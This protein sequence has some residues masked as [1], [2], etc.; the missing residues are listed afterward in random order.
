MALFGFGGDSFVEVVSGI[1][2][3][4]M[5]RRIRISGTENPDPFQQ[6]A[7]TITGTGFYVLVL[8]LSLTA[9]VGLYRGH[10]PDTTFWGFVVSVVSLVT[11][12]LLIHYKVEVGKQLNSDAILSDAAGTRACFSFQS[13]CSL[14][15]SVTNSPISAGLT[16]SVRS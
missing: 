1:G 13:F 10:K 12:W 3:W 2:I 6:T 5:V 14:Q 11:M 16:P 15:T 9:A 8:G 4:H 7:L